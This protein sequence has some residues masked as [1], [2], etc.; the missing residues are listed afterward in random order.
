MNMLMEAALQAAPALAWDSRQCAALIDELQALRS[1]ML[2]HER[3]L[4]PW[5]AQTGGARSASARNLAHYLT[6]RATDLRELQERLARLGL[7]SLGRGES[8]V[9]ANLDK[10]LGLLH[11]LTGRPWE[12]QAGRR[13]GRL[14]Q[15]RRTPGA[16]CGGAVRPAAARTP[17]AH[18][19]HPAGQRRTGSSA[20]RCTGP[21]RH[22]R[23]AHQLRPRR[24]AGLD[25]W[26]RN[27]RRAA[28]HQRPAGQGADGP[29]RAED[30]H[31]TDRRGPSV[32]KIKPGRDE[33]GQVTRRRWSACARSAQRC[34][35]TAPRRR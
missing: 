7:S 34:L 29:G 33:F 30:P 27:V 19:G 13:T 24:C 2:A 9:L 8:H 16:P 6:L 21:R 17:R 32:L 10:V 1:A 12:A 31:R 22:G 18:H 23:G 4:A 35:S 14:R 11:V 20:D 28:A 5:I 15:R 26:P 25:A 3:T